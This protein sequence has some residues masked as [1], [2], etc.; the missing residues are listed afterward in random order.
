VEKTLTMNSP[1][2][3]SYLSPFASNLCMFGSAAKDAPPSGEYTSN[4]WPDSDF[5][6]VF[7]LHFSCISHYFRVVCMYSVKL[8]PFQSRNA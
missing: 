4:K 1:S 3:T 2:L 8:N 5:L 6:L 7:C